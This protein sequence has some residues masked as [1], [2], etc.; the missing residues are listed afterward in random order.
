[1]KITLLFLL[2]HFFA[3]AEAPKLFLLKNYTQQSD[4]RGWVM[5]EK[6]DGVRAYWDGKQLV[7]RNG[8][9][10]TP[11]SSFTADFPPFA[12]DGE[13]WSRRGGFEEVVSVIN[14]KEAHEGW[15]ALS[16]NVFEVPSQRG[17]L[18]ERLAVLENYLV[19]HPT[20]KIK[21]V[22]QRVIKEQEEI[23]AY[24]EEVMAKGGEGLVLRDPLTPYYSGRTDDALKYKSFIDA[25]CRVL[26][27]IEG[28]GKLEGNMGAVTC[29]YQGKVIKIGSGFSS[30]QRSSPPQIGTV[31][32]F[33]YYG[34]THLGNPK[35]P[36]F[37]RVRSDAE[38]SLTE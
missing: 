25:D 36:V 5:S 12:I 37:L 22:K 10:F 19:L 13:L 11:P 15:D 26:S 2:L 3:Y 18:F 4:L 16:M 35:Y 7:S 23:K 17:G 9:V 33:K 6:L 20:S 30:Q 8:K 28:K 24:L 38:L 27:I 29:D 31:I 21:I 32:S 14:T 34:L 1:M